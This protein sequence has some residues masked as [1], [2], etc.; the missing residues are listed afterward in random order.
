MTTATKI[1]N[2]TQEQTALAKSA[3]VESP[4]KETVAKLAELFGKTAKS[5]IAKLS[6]EGVYVKA[7]RVSKAGGVVVSKDALVT[8]I[9]HLMGVNEE[10]LD[11]LEAAPKASLI[12]IANAMLW[13]QS[14][15]DTAKRDVPGA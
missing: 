13:Q 14:V 2:Y 3:Y 1:V 9:A 4:T 10:K 15:I 11:G 6:R 5:V 7:V 8:N 12:L